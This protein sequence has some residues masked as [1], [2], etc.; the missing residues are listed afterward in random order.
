MI[1]RWHDYTEKDDT[2][3]PKRNIPQNCIDR[4]RLHKYFRHNSRATRCDTLTSPTS[5]SLPA[6]TS[7]SLPATP[8]K[9]QKS[10]GS[11]VSFTPPNCGGDR[12]LMLSYAA[13]RIEEFEQKEKECIKI[14]AIFGS[15]VPNFDYVYYTY[16]V[17]FYLFR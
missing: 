9:S 3:E 2:W 13:Q 12:V 5:S 10:N 11:L 6:V 15:K 16:Y 4:F 17:L 1:F 14:L 8:I 7:S